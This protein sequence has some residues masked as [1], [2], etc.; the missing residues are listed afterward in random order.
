MMLLLV[1]LSATA[2]GQESPTQN[3][4]WWGGLSQGDKLMFVWGYVTAMGSA[5]LSTQLH[6][7]SDMTKG[8]A[9]LKE[10]DY[11]AAKEICDASNEVKEQ[12]FGGVRLGQFVDGV[13]EFYKDYRNKNIDFGLALKY[14]RDEL[15]GA[16]PEKLKSDL[17]FL[18]SI[19]NN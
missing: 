3:A 15:K 2:G 9:N 11:Q 4:Y 13:N 8:K 14:V 1:A 6:C 16:T 7:D 19:A 5:R 10:Q 12:D 18:R 17:T